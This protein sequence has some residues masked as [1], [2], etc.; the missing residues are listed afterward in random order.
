MKRRSATVLTALASATAAALTTMLAFGLPASAHDGDSAKTGATALGDPDYGVCRGL[1]ARC[2]HNWGNFDPAKGY[3][4][5]LYTRTAGPR[6]AN[7]GPALAPGLNPPLTDANVVQKAMVRARRGERV[8]R[9]LDR[10]RHPAGHPE[11]AVQVQRG[12]LHSAPAATRST[13]PRR[14]RCAST[15]AAAAGSSAIHNAFGTEYN[16]PWYEGLLGGANFYDHGAEPARDRRADGRPQGRLHRRACRP[17]GPSPTSGTTWCPFP[18]KVR[19][20]AKV[21]ES[22][23]A[24]GVTG[25]YGP[26]RPRQQPPGRLVPV[27]RRRPLLG[28]HAGPRGLGVHQHDHG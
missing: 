11:R 16:W 14:P 22:T 20:L 17:G 3:K 26:P 8:H 4:V 27:L 6:H 12:R 9:R 23:L 18:T 13:T 28:D 7:L 15:S 21:D 2:Y 24:K 5:L 19:V 25:N 10:G 1:D